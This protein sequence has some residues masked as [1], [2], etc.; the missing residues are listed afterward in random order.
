MILWEWSGSW[1]WVMDGGGEVEDD[2]CCLPD[3]NSG[4]SLHP[5]QPDLH[6][7]SRHGQPVPQGSPRVSDVR[8]SKQGWFRPGSSQMRVSIHPRKRGGSRLLFRRR[9]H[10]G[11]GEPF[12][13]E[14]SYLTQFPL[15]M[16]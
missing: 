8:Y 13:K 1:P 16:D 7:T 14:L 11:N 4:S 6:L 12:R 5:S 3:S 10:V 15:R 9:T 2:F